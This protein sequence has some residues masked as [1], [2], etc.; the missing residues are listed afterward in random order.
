[1][2]RVALV[3]GAAGGIGTA[4][5]STLD[6]AGWTV[7]AADQSGCRFPVD[8]TN[9]DSVAALVD[10]VE[11]TC[12]PIAALV[13]A[14]GVLR[15]GSVL[16]SEVTDA[17]AMLQVNALGVLRVARSVA[18]RMVPRGHGSIV[19]IASNAA[20][21]PRAGMAAY[22]ASKAAASAFTRSLGVEL[23]PAGIRCNVVCPG[24]TRTPMLAAFGAPVDVVAAQ[25]I[26]GDQ[27]RFKL[28]I[29]LGRVAEPG[30]VAAAVAFLVSDAARHITTHELVVDGGAS[31][32]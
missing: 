9:D 22:A 7:A 18:G 21:V 8:V 27:V 1:M 15:V 17:V 11:Q 5:A 32:R 4:V 2:A 31:L 24:T 26:A 3:I 13:N 16:E 6:E 19:T 12:G 23:A 30:D 14:A 25:A 10:T 28:G 20:G 29:P